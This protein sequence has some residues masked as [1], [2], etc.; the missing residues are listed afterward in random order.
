MT[1]FYTDMSSDAMSDNVIRK[2]GDCLVMPCLITLYG[3]VV[4]VMS[5]NAGRRLSRHSGPYIVKE[6]TN[7]FSVFSSSK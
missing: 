7:H 2:C 6:L 1:Y 3:N 5:E 4:I